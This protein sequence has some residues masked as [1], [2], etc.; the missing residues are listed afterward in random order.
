MG[1]TYFCAPEPCFSA[2]CLTLAN[3]R[4]ARPRATLPTGLGAGRLKVDGGVR[5]GANT[6]AG[7]DRRCRN[8]A[9]VLQVRQRRRARGS[10]ILTEDRNSV[11][12]AYVRVVSQFERVRP[13]SARLTEDAAGVSRHPLPLG[14]HRRS[15]S[16]QTRKS[17]RSAVDRQSYR[18]STTSSRCP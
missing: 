16:A 18:H 9:S 17:S 5:R 6:T 15:R 4:S 2:S 3:L 13:G 10:A 12:T 7:C 1:A 8:R 14:S 11:Q